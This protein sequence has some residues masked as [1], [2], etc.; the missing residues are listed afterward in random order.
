MKL[1]SLAVFTVVLLASAAYANGSIEVAGGT[2][3]FSVGTNIPAVTIHG[4]SKA[5]TGTATVNRSGDTL[6][7]ENADAKIPVVSLTTG[8][9]LRDNHMRKLVFTS[10]NGELSDLSYR[11]GKTECTIAKNNDGGSTCL[12]K[13]ELAIRGVARPLSLTLNLRDDGSGRFRVAG[14]GAVRLTDYGIEPPSQLGVRVDEQV[15]LRFEFS[16]TTS[17]AMSAARGQ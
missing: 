17:T 6:T 11:S 14:S 8:M 12:L 10:P 3:N 13:G 7:I 2:A 5:L 15:Q 16:V 9:G 4:K 1:V